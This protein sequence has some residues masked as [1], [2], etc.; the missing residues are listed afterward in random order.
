MDWRT[1]DAATGEPA[2]GCHAADRAGLAGGVNTYLDAY[3]QAT[4][5][6][7]LA[8]LRRLVEAEDGRPVLVI[9]DFNLAP[10]PEDGRYDG[11]PS[12]FNAEIDRAPFG[13]LLAETGL[14]DCTAEPAP[15]QY[16]F[17]RKVRGKSS[18]RV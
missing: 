15:I 7:Q 2:R 18:E 16:S 17:S 12:I 10:R 13:A 11:R 6:D 8:R 1:P 14:V 3:A 9:G 5:A 4:R